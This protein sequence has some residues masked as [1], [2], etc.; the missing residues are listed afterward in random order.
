MMPHRRG[1][2]SPGEVV[3][4]K[5]TKL[6][7][8]S[9]FAQLLEY[10]GIEGMIHISEVARGWVRDIRHHVKQ[11][12]EVV[13]VV[14]RMEP[15][16]LSVKRVSDNQ[17]AQKTKEYNMDKRAEKMLENIAQALGKSLDEAYKEAGYLLQERF[18]SL[19][20]AFKESMTSPEKVKSIVPSLWFEKIKETA[21]KEIGQKEFEFRAHLFLKSSDSNGIERV[22]AALAAAEK[23]GLDVHY[24]AAPRYLVRFTTKDPK[25]GRR[26]FEE[27][28]ESFT[29]ENKPLEARFEMLEA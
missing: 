9:A 8:N 1:R 15:L 28:L 11:D 27:R 6:N 19:Y 26:D 17:A 16:E 13:A 5:V 12:Q 14:F 10:P 18:G 25:R 7:P 4:A 22:K 21:E 29:K 2:P 20:A 24:L 3:V 23:R